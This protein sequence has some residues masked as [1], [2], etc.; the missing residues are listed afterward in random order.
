MA[1]VIDLVDLFGYLAT[2]A[3]VRYPAT[4]TVVAR[5]GETAAFYLRETVADGAGDPLALTV[6][7]PGCDLVVRGGQSLR[8]R[9]RSGS[10]IHATGRLRRRIFET[11]GNL[12]CRTEVLCA[13]E[14]VQVL[15]TP[16]GSRP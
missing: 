4:G 14:E 16:D 12:V 9:L 2:D 1:F 8:P 5:L 7:Q 15:R 3:R 6:W 10:Q 13:A 11:R